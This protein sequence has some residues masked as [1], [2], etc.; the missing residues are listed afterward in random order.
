MTCQ[1]FSDQFDLLYNNIT[2]NQA[3]GLNEWEKS[4]F[5]TKAQEE[6]L[7]NYFN[8]K[9]NP[10]QEGFDATQKRQID[11]SVLM[12][13]AELAPV[14][15]SSYVKFDFRSESHPYQFPSD[16]FLPV[17]EQ[18]LSGNIPY[19]VVPISYDEYSRLMSKPYKYPLKYQ[20]W[21]L[22]TNKSTTT[23]TETIT[24]YESTVSSGCKVASY[25][26]RPYIITL[27]AVEG[28]EVTLNIYS[29]L[30]TLPA[31]MTV[32]DDKVSIS[33]GLCIDD[34]L[35]D[36]DPSDYNIDSAI[37]RIEGISNYIVL[38]ACSFPNAWL[39]AEEH[40]AGTVFWELTAGKATT[41]TITKTTNCPI[42]ELIGRFVSGI[43]Y[44][45]RYIRRPKPIILID[46]NGTN[47]LTING[48]T[49]V[50]ECEL[51]EELHEE[52][53]Q[54]AVELAKIAWQG[55]VNST[56]QTGQRSE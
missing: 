16:L 32:N 44:M 30:Q 11:F 55:D 43:K 56:I 20:A 40:Q 37:R 24:V 25:N 9:S 26:S 4:V 1:E 38:D 48:F 41:K 23:G 34:P 22:M 8:P 5:L 42:V 21:R 50:T 49:N 7:K 3:P 18:V 31:T 13:S 35:E 47:S 2:S 39:P 14:T 29:S 17:N 53:L 15:D 45:I 10:K 52:I 46:L 19:T 6:I 33:L 54:R 27:T 12:K 51:P 36:A 28:Y